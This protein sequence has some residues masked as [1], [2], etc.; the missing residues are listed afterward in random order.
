MTDADPPAWLR[1]PERR[2]EFRYWD[3]VRWSGHVSTAGFLGIDPPGESSPR[4]AAQPPK[5]APIR[6]TE[7]GRARGREG[8]D[9][10]AENLPGRDASVIEFA[11]SRGTR[12]LPGAV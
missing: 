9:P 12:G 2:Y 8:P 5:L 6:W 3:G 7:E 10:S 4:P 1:D 11:R